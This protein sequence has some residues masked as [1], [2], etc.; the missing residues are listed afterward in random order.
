MSFSEFAGDADA[1]RRAASRLL[2]T[3]ARLTIAAAPAWRVRGSYGDCGISAEAPD[4]LRPGILSEFDT[5]GW[6]P[7][8]ILD[9]GPVIHGVLNHEARAAER[10]TQPNQAVVALARRILG[11]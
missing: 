1:L 5:W 10:G 3:E 4:Q 11:E 9:A 6:A 8:M 2:D 7:A